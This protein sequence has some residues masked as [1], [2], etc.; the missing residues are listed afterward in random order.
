[1]SFLLRSRSR[2]SVVTA[3]ELREGWAALGLH[4]HVMV[5]ASLSQFGYI[6]GG[7]KTL[8]DTLLEVTDTLVAPAF[9]YDT[10]LNAA[11]DQPRHFFHRD[12]RVSRDI[13]RL[14]QEMV[15]RR[16]SL[17]SFHPALSFVAIGDHAETILT[18]QSLDRPYQPVGALLDLDGWVLLLGV[19]FS[20][21]TAI[22]YGEYLAG[23]PQLTRYV[24]LDGEVRATSFPNCS[25]DFEALRVPPRARATIGKCEAWLYSVRDL[26]EATLRQIEIMPDFLICR[27]RYC[28]CREVRRLI[29][30]Q[31]LQP[32][33]H[34]PIVARSSLA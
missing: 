33:E 12:T 19:D 13:G 17:R 8:L 21:N 26:I 18:T 31:G 25:A 22:H 23:V 30:E 28:R 14:P 29:K 24:P 11:T 10:L 32:R 7:A 1:M 34:S 16:E 9:S 6:E 3:A 27:Y 4:G 5:H 20:S 15:E 2:S